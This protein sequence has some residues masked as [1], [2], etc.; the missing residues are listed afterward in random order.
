MGSVE[1]SGEGGWGGKRGQQFD[2]LL[3]ASGLF[4]SLPDSLQL[5]KKKHLYTKTVISVILS[6]AFSVLPSLDINATDF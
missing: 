5:K 1:G 2:I 6:H 3:K 4:R